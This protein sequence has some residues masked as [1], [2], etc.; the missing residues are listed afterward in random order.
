MKR[1]VSALLALAVLAAL[2]HVITTSKHAVRAVYAQSGCS[3]ATLNGSYAFS[4]PGWGPLHGQGQGNQ[5][6][7]F[8]VGV[9]A[10]GGTGTVSVS[11]T[12]VQSGVVSTETDAGT[13]TVN[14]DC[15]GS[16]SFTTGP[17]AGA[18]FNIVIIGGGPELFGINTSAGFTSSF[19]AK[20]Q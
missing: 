10:F 16:M 8:N 13:Y 5:L 14:P 15:T 17:G 18:A 7:F 12:S 6:P 4:Q 19:D 9:A 20:K 3:V 1:I 2:V 11:F